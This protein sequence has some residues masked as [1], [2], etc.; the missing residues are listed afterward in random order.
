VGR[1]GQ[2]EIK[3]FKRLYIAGSRSISRSPPSLSTS[4]HRNFGA[5]C[6]IGPLVDLLVRANAALHILQPFGAVDKKRPLSLDLQSGTG[7]GIGGYAV[8]TLP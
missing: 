5:D 2:G 1:A 6:S 3:C 7:A 8:H 4:D